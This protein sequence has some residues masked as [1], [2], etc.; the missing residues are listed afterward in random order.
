MDGLPVVLIEDGEP[1]RDPMTRAR[2]DEGDILEAARNF[3]G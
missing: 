2:V 3:H 1:H